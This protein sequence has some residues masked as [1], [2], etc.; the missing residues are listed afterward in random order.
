MLRT[1][2]SNPLVAFAQVDARGLPASIAPYVLDASIG[3]GSVTTPKIADLAVTKAKL[4]TNIQ[5]FSVSI[6]QSSV[7]TVGGS[8]GED[9]AIPGVLASDFGWATV[10]FQGASMPVLLSSSAQANK[11]QTLFSTDPGNDTFVLLSVFRAT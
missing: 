11:I 10:E 3:D 2:A 6:H 4:S 7:T 8:P 1:A 5:P 9:F